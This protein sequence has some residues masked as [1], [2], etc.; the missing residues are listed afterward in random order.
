MCPIMPRFQKPQLVPE[1]IAIKAKKANARRMV[2]SIRT[3]N[4]RMSH[5]LFFR[6]ASIAVM[7]AI[8]ILSFLPGSAMPNVPG[9]DKWHHALAYFALMFCWGQWFVRPLPRLK[10][11][12]SFVVMGALIE[13]LQGL[14]TYRSFEWL[15]MLADAIGVAI[16]WTAVTVQLAVQRRFA[17]QARSARPPD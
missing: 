4:M 11:A 3:Y 1:C 17:P 2:F 12:I 16:A 7:L 5:S 15:D 10:L 6:L 9:T 8:W 13:C 14:T